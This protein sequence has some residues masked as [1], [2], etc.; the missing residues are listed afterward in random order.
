MTRESTTVV[1]QLTTSYR[2][3][4]GDVSRVFGVQSYSDNSKHWSSLEE[5]RPVIRVRD[6]EMVPSNES[7]AVSLITPPRCVELVT[8]LA[9]ANRATDKMTNRRLVSERSSSVQASWKCSKFVI[10]C[11]ICVGFWVYV[12][13]YPIVSLMLLDSRESR[14]WVNDYESR[15]HRFLKHLLYLK[16]HRYHDDVEILLPETHRISGWRSGS[17]KLKY[18]CG[19]AYDM[20]T[21]WQHEKK[22]WDHGRWF[23]KGN[24]KHSMYQDCV[25]YTT[26]THSLI[27]VLSFSLIHT[28]SR[29]TST[30]CWV[31]TRIGVW[32]SSR[33]ICVKRNSWEKKTYANRSW[34]APPQTDEWTA[35]VVN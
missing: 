2:Y 12:R 21:P 25:Q 7:G 5:M 20:L 4:L 17:A 9:P 10:I 31:S 11:A 1:N 13:R 6:R 27:S 3:V 35:L 8:T 29:T 26:K 30:S 28:T 24:L 16:V 19:M 22:V 18:G 34:N 15:F 32:S 14:D 33:T 23:G